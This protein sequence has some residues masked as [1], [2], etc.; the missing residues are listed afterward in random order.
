MASIS[1]LDLVSRG[2][3][4]GFRDVVWRGRWRPRGLRSSGHQPGRDVADEASI[5]ASSRE[6]EP[7]PGS[8][9]YDAGAEL[10]E[11]QS[12]GGKLGSGEGV[13]FWG[14]RFGR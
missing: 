13:R 7:D 10:Q 14:L 4:W 1:P 3:R 6:G 11:A 2:R 5:Q 8:G 12:E 9:F